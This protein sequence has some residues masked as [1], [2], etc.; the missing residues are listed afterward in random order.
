PD[1][2]ALAAA[3][4]L[5]L[6]M[7]RPGDPAPGLGAHD[8]LAAWPPIDI[9]QLEGQRLVSHRPGLGVHP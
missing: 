1:G 5:A 6:A 8:G 3:V 7:A 2:T 9:P 4:E